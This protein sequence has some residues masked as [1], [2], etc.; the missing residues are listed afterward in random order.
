MATSVK[1]HAESNIFHTERYELLKGAVILGANS[2]GKSNF[3]KAVSTM[4]RLVLRSFEQSS[5]DEL[6]ITP[7]LLSTKTENNPSFFEVVFL[8]ENVRYRF[9]FEVD[10][11]RVHAEWL[12]EAQKLAEKPLFIREQDGI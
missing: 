2:S 6:G 1:E 7:F 4:R 11:R 9:G 10:G 12:F 8:I 3:I 5:A